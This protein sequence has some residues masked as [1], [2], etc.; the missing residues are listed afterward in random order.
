MFLHCDRQ[1]IAVLCHPNIT[2]PSVQKKRSMI[3]HFVAKL[4]IFG[5]LRNSWHAQRALQEGITCSSSVP[6]SSFTAT[7]WITAGRVEAI[8][9]GVPDHIYRQKQNIYR[10]RISKAEPAR[11]FRIFGAMQSHK[12]ISKKNVKELWTIFVV[13]SL[14]ILNLVSALSFSK[15]LVSQTT[16][17]FFGECIIVFRG[18][19]WK[20]KTT[21]KL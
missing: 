7:K 11:D 13:W 1:M 2:L 4:A 16:L 17:L 12:V 10:H 19:C 15:V 6:S 8:G 9:F 18:K 5:A 20:F 3:Q 14:H 21:V